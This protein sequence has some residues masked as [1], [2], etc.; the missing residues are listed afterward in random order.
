MTDTRTIQR[1][2]LE[3]GLTADTLRYYERIGILPG[4]GRSTSG[5]RRFTDDDMGW[6]KLVQCLRATGMPLEDLHRYAELVQEGEHTAAERLSLLEAHKCRIEVELAELMVAL[7]LVDQ[8]IDGYT[9]LV[10][11]GFDLEPPDHRPAPRR[12]RPRSERQH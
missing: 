8:K 10:A 4:I 7:D 6:I 9:Q 2:A 12:V 5:H 11:K 3:T 1:A